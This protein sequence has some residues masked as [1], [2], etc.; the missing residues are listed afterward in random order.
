[1]PIL[2]SGEGPTAS[3]PNID[4]SFHFFFV[5]PDKIWLN[6]DVKFKP[7]LLQSSPNIC[8]NHYLFEDEVRRAQASLRPLIV[9]GWWFRLP[10]RFT[11]P[12]SEILSYLKI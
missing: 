4:N 1:M 2:F 7:I 3:F 9:R 10:R 8:L 5:R 11:T 6:T 12:N